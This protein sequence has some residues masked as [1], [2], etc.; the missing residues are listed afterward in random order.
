[1]RSWSSHPALVRASHDIPC[2][3]LHHPSSLP[4]PEPLSA[5][6]GPFDTGS[7]LKE[8]AE[9]ANQLRRRIA[10]TFPSG[11]DSTNTNPHSPSPPLPEPFSVD[12]GTIH[13][14][15]DCDEISATVEPSLRWLS[16]IIETS[17]S[18][19]TEL[20]QCGTVNSE[21]ESN[22]N[23]LLCTLDAANAGLVHNE[24]H[25][26]RTSRKTVH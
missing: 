14:Q 26:Q 8:I 10:A 17:P 7:K 19:L 9:R 25:P 5:D 1:M 21:E 24:Y 23:Q 11:K 20:P 6:E 16:T 12:D 15:S 22:V 18:L 4:Q 13:S 2:L 3:T